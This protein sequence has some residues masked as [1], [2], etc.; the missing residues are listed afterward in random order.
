M[1]AGNLLF[2]AGSAW[3]VALSGAVMPGPVL[4]ATIGETMKRGFRAGPLIVAGH[5]MLEI[6]VVAAAA[7]G[8]GR[9][10]AR[11]GVLAALGV[12]G[13][14]VLLVLGAQMAAG[15]R[16]AAEEAARGLAPAA[17]VRGPVLAGILTSVSNPYWLLWWATVGLNFMAVAMRSG[18]GGLAA[19]YV[20]HIG[21]DL[22]WYSLVSAAVASGRR[23][24]SPAAHRRVIV[25]CGVVVAVLGVY[26]L[27]AGAGAAAALA[28]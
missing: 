19:F 25:A 3:V 24:C 16:R 7:A 6:V 28:G 18:P 22:A 27:S 4:T 8:L 14:L 23:V 10:I 5:A 9:W 21:G 26:F 15:A 12:A 20:G 1:S 2:I 17:G 11:D 13:G